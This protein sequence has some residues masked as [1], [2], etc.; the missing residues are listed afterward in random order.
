MNPRGFI[1]FLTFAVIATM[2]LWLRVTQLG[3]RPMHC[4]EANQAVRTGILLEKGI[5]QYD[6]HEHHGPTL[7]YCALPVLRMRGARTL[8]E[9]TETDFRIVPVAFGFGMVVL[10]WLMRR[11]LGVAATLWAALFAAIS[12]GLV[13]Y[14]RYYIQEP[15][16]VFFA[17]AAVITG[18]RYVQ[19]PGFGWAAAC[20]AAVGLMHATKETCVILYA[21]MGGALVIAWL[22][23]Y[24]REGVS[25][26]QSLRGIRT[27]HM[28]VGLAMAAAV[29]ITLFSSFFTH[30]RGP[31]DSILALGTYFARADGTGS[32]GIHDKP[33][34]Y[35]L[36]LLL[37]T[38]RSAGPRWSEG[39]IV[40]LA[41]VGMIA[42]FLKRS[43]S[44]DHSTDSDAAETV[45]RADGSV[46]FVRFL[47]IYMLLLIFLFSTIPYKTPWN[48]L[49]FLHAMAILAGV[50]AA[51]LVRLGKVF[52]AKVVIAAL[53]LAGATQLAQ[54]TRL[55]ITHYAA[56]PRN[57]Y[58]Y[59]HT[60]TALMRLVR[61]VDEIAAIHPDG[62]QMHINIIRPDSDYWPLPWYLRGYRRVGYW[63]RFPEP[64]DAP[65]IIADPA[66]QERL[67][68]TLKSEY[69]VEYHALRPSV[70]LL[71]YIRQDLWDAFMASRSGA[72]RNGPANP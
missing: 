12:H 10:I 67:D 3:A 53:I 20:G 40:G 13:F 1:F 22:L 64:P 19:K 61:R 5:Y 8:A 39:I 56:D 47:S 28:A 2:G 45:S 71:A 6:P 46:H 24:L 4:D 69:L 55:G 7:Y 57:P 35:Y 37:F 23:A 14:S 29:S 41:A 38:Y 21:A 49:V 72:M 26:R 36:H 18:W 50:G 52:P 16:L 43:N 31:L 65:F 68:A 30:A 58:V 59:A 11:E 54:Q 34:H 48:L 66:L 44:Q 33:W 17:T 51:A 42:A 9:S 15:M 32:S 25:L 60:S 63:T 27:A 70:L 62:R